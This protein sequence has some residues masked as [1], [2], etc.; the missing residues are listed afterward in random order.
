MRK[1][2][3]FIMCFILL[4]TLAACDSITRP[5]GNEPPSGGNGTNSPTLPIETSAQP[6][7]SYDEV[8]K[9]VL[10]WSGR[11]P[12]KSFED[13]A[14]DPEHWFSETVFFP[15]GRVEYT[16][17]SHYGIVLKSDSWQV[18][19]DNFIWLVSILNEQGFFT[20][21]EVFV[22]GPFDASAYTLSVHVDDTVY[23][24][25]YGPSFDIMDDEESYEIH[26]ACCDAFKN[27]TK[28]P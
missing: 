9:I 20:L 10:Q 26:T 27:K 24:S 18:D 1:S 23:S 7:F 5:A 6:Q 16:E 2:I 17:S 22:Y 15:D 4:L 8:S 11:W 28:K 21:P 25:G 13:D 19:S 12:P 3:F 14:N